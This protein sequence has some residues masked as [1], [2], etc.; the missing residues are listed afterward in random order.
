MICV[1]INIMPKMLS[2]K[3]N[4]YSIQNIPLRVTENT[5][6]NTQIK[7]HKLVCRI[8]SKKNTR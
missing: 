6:N 2:I 1:V 4:L 5:N 3:L 8:I 7:Q